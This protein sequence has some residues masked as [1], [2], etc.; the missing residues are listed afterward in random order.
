VGVFQTKKDSLL[1]FEL[2]HSVA[3]LSLIPIFPRQENVMMHFLT[4]KN[5]QFTHIQQ[6]SRSDD[7]DLQC[8]IKKFEYLRSHPNDL[9]QLLIKAGIYNDRGQ[10]TEEYGG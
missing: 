3:I 2:F 7:D 5:S 4:Q 8:I 6:V 9:N 1:F 10:L